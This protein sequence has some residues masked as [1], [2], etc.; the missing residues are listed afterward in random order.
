[1]SVAVELI[2]TH[3]NKAYVIF[4]GVLLSSHDLSSVCME[5]KCNPCGTW[6]AGRPLTILAAINNNAIR[7]AAKW[8]PIK[9]S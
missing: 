2:F 8:Q 4:V 7:A 1:M 6:N 9:I 3:G 5:E